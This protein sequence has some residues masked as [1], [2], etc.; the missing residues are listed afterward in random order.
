MWQVSNGTW[1]CFFPKHLNHMNS[2]LLF[3]N[4]SSTSSHKIVGISSH[5]NLTWKSSDVLDESSQFDMFHNT[6]SMHTTQRQLY[7]KLCVWFWLIQ[8]KSENLYIVCL[9]F[10]FL[11]SAMKITIARCED[12][13]LLAPHL[14]HIRREK[15]HHSHG[16]AAIRRSHIR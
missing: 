13:S 1:T 9:L 2:L 6:S 7:S 12:L 14:S 8:R 5:M 4:M 15:S 3:R 10:S 11:G 16:T